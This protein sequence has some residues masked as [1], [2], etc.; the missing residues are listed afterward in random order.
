MTRNT[1]L[2][3]IIGASV[4][5]F[6]AT[7]TVAFA[8]NMGYRGNHFGPGMMGQ[9]TCPWNTTAQGTYGPGPGM[10][11]HQGFNQTMP[12]P[13]RGPN[14]PQGI[15]CGMNPQCPAAQSPTT[16]ATP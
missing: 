5:L 1:V 4:G 7:S 3:A 10:M 16:N 2:K 13:M 11:R 14:N 12:G 9:Q 8:H 15:P 6:L